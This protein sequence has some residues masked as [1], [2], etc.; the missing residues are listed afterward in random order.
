MKTFAERLAKIDGRPF[1]PEDYQEYVD[2]ALKKITEVKLD[3]RLTLLEKN[4]LWSSITDV[5]S[6]LI[7]GKLRDAYTGKI[8]FEDKSR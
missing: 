3:Q 2:L 6:Y 1:H 8:I 7:D 4:D 5:Y